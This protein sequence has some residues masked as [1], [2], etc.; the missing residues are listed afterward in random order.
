MRV[1]GASSGAAVTE[2]S[3]HC[4]ASPCSL[5][6]KAKQGRRGPGLS[7]R[8]TSQGLQIAALSFSPLLLLGVKK[9]AV[10]P[11]E[12]DANGC[13]ILTISCINQ[14]FPCKVYPC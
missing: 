8:K 2:L 1:H 9:K 7:R 5:V 6:R 4:R 11:L 10:L 3:L 14:A 12:A 13:R